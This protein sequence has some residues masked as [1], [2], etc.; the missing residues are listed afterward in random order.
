MSLFITTESAISVLM[1]SVIM[2]YAVSVTFIIG[3]SFIAFWVEC[4]RWV[5]ISGV[6][7]TVSHDKKITF[8]FLVP[9]I[10]FSV[11]TSMGSLSVVENLILIAGF[12]ALSA[13]SIIDSMT[14]YLPNT[15]TY[16]MCIAG[17]TINLL[18]LGI[19]SL[20]IESVY[21]CATGYI[22]FWMINKAYLKITGKEGMG[23]GDAKLL[24]A[25]LAWIGASSILPIM[26]IA[27]ISAIVWFFVR[28]KTHKEPDD[29]GEVCSDQTFPFGPHLGIGAAVMFC[30][31]AKPIF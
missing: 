18:E 20:G 1:Y 24:A 26:L 16:T 7:I 19:F 5:A 14:G 10:A 8:S 12:A 31:I 6:P 15:Y 2:Y 29:D 22:V 21:A 13:V 27:N 3:L 9:V 4:R 17:C 11:W 28:T 23:M 30:Q 25:I